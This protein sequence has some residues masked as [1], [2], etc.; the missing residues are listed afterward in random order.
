MPREWPWARTTCR[1][2]TNV[3]LRIEKRDRD[4][5]FREMVQS[6]IEHQHLSTGELTSFYVVNLLCAF[7]QPDRRRGS[8]IT[9]DEALA[10]RLSRALDSGG[11]EQRLE[12][13]RLG[14]VS[15][16]VAGFFSDS[17]RR[18]LVDV[19]YYMSLGGNAYSS[20]SR[21]EEESFAEVFGE[22][23]EKFGAFVEVLSEVSERSGLASSTDLLRLYEKWLRTGGRRSGQLLVEH[24]IV[25]NASIG[26]RFI[27]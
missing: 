7:V 6:A 1:E 3:G 22:L 4:W 23:G 5:Y 17:F 21:Y 24:G 14:D 9:F 18:R 25:P 15:L 26:N 13:K 11:A 19:D 2:S 16:F 8:D 10:K 12:L 27:Q 20:L